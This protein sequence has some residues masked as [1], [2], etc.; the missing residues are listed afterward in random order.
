MF[1]VCPSF[2]TKKAA[3]AEIYCKYALYRIQ[4]SSTM[5]GM[6]PSLSSST[7]N[8]NDPHFG[9]TVPNSDVGNIF[10]V[11]M[12]S[13]AML[14]NRSIMLHNEKPIYFQILLIYLGMRCCALNATYIC[15]FRSVDVLSCSLSLS[16]SLAFFAF[17]FLFFDSRVYM[18]CFPASFSIGKM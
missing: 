7:S 12:H 14:V 8:R 15:C 4:F 3:E 11:Y 9:F 16:L 2:E 6:S 18:L 5:L 10:L 13:L 17:P 1:F